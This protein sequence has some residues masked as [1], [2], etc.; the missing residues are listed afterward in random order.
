MFLGFGFLGI[1]GDFWG[2]L[3]IFG[4][5]WASMWRQDFR[6]L[7]I[8]IF[9]NN[10]SGFCFRN[11]SSKNPKA[12][13]ATKNP[14]IPKSQNHKSPKS[15]IYSVRPLKTKKPELFITNFSGATSS[16]YEYLEQGCRATSILARTNQGAQMA[17][18]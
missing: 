17:R 10:F 6:G 4:D 12:R 14:K 16:K 3:G 11:R 15:K 1:F 18:N 7:G 8:K 13:A 9:Q 2:F 5:F